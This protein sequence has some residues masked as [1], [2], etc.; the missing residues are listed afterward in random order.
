[1][2][3]HYHFFLKRDTYVAKIKANNY[4]R[5]GKKRGFHVLPSTDIKFLSANF[6]EEAWWKKKSY[7]R[8]FRIG[9]NGNSLEI[10]H[11]WWF[12]SLISDPAHRPSSPWGSGGRSSSP[13]FGYSVLLSHTF[14]HS[15]ICLAYTGY[16]RLGAEYVQSNWILRCEKVDR[17]P[18]WW[19]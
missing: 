3:F 14:P 6:H 18:R 13:S 7:G 19:I 9:E 10:L 4:I 16:V 8:I 5:E 17:E 2:K 15:W 12:S 1:M 11:R